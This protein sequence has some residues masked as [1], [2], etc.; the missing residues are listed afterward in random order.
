M[1]NCLAHITDEFLVY[2]TGKENSN[3][4]IKREEKIIFSP[5]KF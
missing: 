5:R 4:K 1:K 2:D 3:L